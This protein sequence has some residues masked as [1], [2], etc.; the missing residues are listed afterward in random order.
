MSKYHINPKTGRPNICDPKVTGVC[1]YTKDGQPPEHYD[2]KDEAKVA[3]EKQGNKE[4][5]TTTTMKKEAKTLKMEKATE[6]EIMEKRIAKLA[7]FFPEEEPTQ[8][9]L[10]IRNKPE[11]I[12]GATVESRRA[13]GYAYFK[14]GT[15]LKLVQVDPKDSAEI[16]YSMDTLKAFSATG[17]LT[18]KRRREVIDRLAKH[19]ILSQKGLIVLESI[20]S[21]Q[22]HGI[23]DYV[24]FNKMMVYVQ[25]AYSDVENNYPIGGTAEVS[26]DFKKLEDNL[27]REDKKKIIEQAKNDAIIAIKNKPAEEV[28]YEFE[29]IQKQYKERLTQRKAVKA[30]DKAY[31]KELK[32]LAKSQSN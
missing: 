4:F 15:K 29:F 7:E 20:L 30:Y 9:L 2:S 13:N 12:F 25:S 18:E 10:P 16:K 8:T 31:L 21:K 23:M 3:Y 32:R 19:K 14:N 22:K 27:K 17:Y 28:I 6:T 26:Q 5:G 11:T 1:K 24:S